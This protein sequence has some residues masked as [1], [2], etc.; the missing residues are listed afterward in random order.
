MGYFTCC[1]V[2]PGGRNCGPKAQ[3]WPEKKPE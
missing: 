1:P 2:L 3:K